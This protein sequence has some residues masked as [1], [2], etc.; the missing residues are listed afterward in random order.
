ML[1]KK[2]MT[3]ARSGHFEERLFIPVRAF[4]VLDFPVRVRRIESS[5]NECVRAMSASFT[6]KN[7]KPGGCYA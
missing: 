7:G 3:K 1:P 2:F 5:G 6:V 4:E